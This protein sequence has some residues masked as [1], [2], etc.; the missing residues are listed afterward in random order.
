M[1]EALLT[2]VACVLPLVRFQISHESMV[3][4]ASSPCFGA[5]ARAANVLQHPA[6]LAA[7]EIGVEH[8]PGLLPHAVLAAFAL[9]LLAQVSRAA[10]LP[11]DRAVNRLAGRAIPDARSSRADW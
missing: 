3:P 6:N 11:D 2:S 5:I 9:E 4:K 10:I 8:E 7:A 1:R